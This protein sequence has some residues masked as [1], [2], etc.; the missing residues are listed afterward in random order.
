MIRIHN[1]YKLFGRTEPNERVDI[2]LTDVGSE[3]VDAAEFKEHARITE[4]DDYI[5]GLLTA[6]RQSI[7][8]YCGISI[9]D[10]EVVLHVKNV[11]NDYELPYGPVKSI[12]TAVDT[13]DEAIEYETG[14]IDYKTIS[15]EHSFMNIAY[16]T[17]FDEV[18]GDL[19]LAIKK[20]ALWDYEHR[21]DNDD[22][23]Q[24]L[25]PEAK[26]IANQYRRITWLA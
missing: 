12:T 5:A 24:G 20:Q 19:K 9:V 18:P 11:T 7:E 26:R 23:V 14:G 2:K 17:G 25:C 22:K 1:Y 13:E 21:G 6:A 16:T 3:P 4:D 15:S 10:K 8:K